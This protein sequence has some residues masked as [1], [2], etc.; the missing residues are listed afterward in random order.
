VLPRSGIDHQCGWTARPGQAHGNNAEFRVGARS[1]PGSAAALT[2][3]GARTHS[4]LAAH[5][6]PRTCGCVSESGNPC[7]HPHG[8]VQSSYRS[9]KSRFERPLSKIS[10]GGFGSTAEV[11][12]VAH[13]LCDVSLV[14]ASKRQQLIELGNDESRAI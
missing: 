13:V 1:A 2:T 6:L 5:R 10:T 3:A 4:V 9:A 8:Y 11:R 14:S 7:P 12:S